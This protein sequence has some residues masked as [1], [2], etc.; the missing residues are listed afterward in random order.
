MVTR[1]A[2]DGLLGYS[3]IAF[4]FCTLEEGGKIQ[5]AVQ[6]RAFAAEYKL[7]WAQPHLETSGVGTRRTGGPREF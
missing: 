6:S 7:G 4:L 2:I 5:D 1:K 3:M